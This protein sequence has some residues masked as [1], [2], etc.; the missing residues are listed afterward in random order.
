MKR[1]WWIVIVGIIILLIFSY[2]I[3]R[4]SLKID[5][6]S[7]GD[8][9]PNLREDYCETSSDCDFF[10]TNY[11]ENSPCEGCYYGSD[12][13][14]CLNKIEGDKMFE[15]TIAEL[16]EDPSDV[17]LCSPCPETDFNLYVCRCLNNRCVKGSI[18]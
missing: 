18:K 17:G 16:F 7:E 5:I 1:G 10:Y 4:T 14:V 8:L 3:F 15:D 13:Y 11:S 12:E 2:F 9:D 6:D